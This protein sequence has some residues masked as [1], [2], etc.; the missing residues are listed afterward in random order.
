MRKIITIDTHYILPQFAA[1][2]LLVENQNA[3]FIETNT[4][5]ALPHLLKSVE[6]IKLKPENVQYIIITHVHLDHAGGVSAA[7]DAFPNAKVICHPRASKHIIDPTKL[8]KSATSVYG[9]DSFKK[10]YGLIKPVDEKKVM[11][12]DDHSELKFGDGVLKFIHTRGHANHHFCIIDEGTS[13]IFTG[14]SFG[15]CY[16]QLQDK[17]LFIFPST[18][19]TDF[20]PDLAI[21]SIKKIV[22]TNANTAYPTHY[23]PITKVKEAG[24]QLIQHL[25]FNKDLLNELVIKIKSNPESITDHTEIKKDLIK[26]YKNYL[27]NLGWNWDSKIE[28]FLELDLDINAQ[29]LLYAANK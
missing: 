20:D 18:S 8:I 6:D 29:G 16:P 4:N 23:G 5:N 22:N 2:Y 11:S 24:E 7:I 13:S 14:D 28:N 26:Y 9:E 15:V 21:E 1:S 25:K 27:Q 12:M 3:C 19:P 17:G 10:L